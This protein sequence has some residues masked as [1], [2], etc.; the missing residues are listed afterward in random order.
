[1]QQCFGLPNG[2]VVKRRHPR[3]VR[4]GQRLR[5]ALTFFNQYSIMHL[6]ATAAVARAEVRAEAEV[7]FAPILHRHARRRSPGTQPGEVG[8]ERAA[9]GL[10]PLSFFVPHEHNRQ[11][12]E[13]IVGVKKEAA[14]L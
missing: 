8:E 3:Q 9:T 6:T 12:A 7:W 14:P 13:S 10:P 1:M 5:E 11:Q 4:V 2:P